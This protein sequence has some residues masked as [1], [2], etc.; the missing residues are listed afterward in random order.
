MEMKHVPG[1][2]YSCLDDSQIT[3][4]RVPTALEYTAT[5]SESRHQGPDHTPAFF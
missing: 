4:I 2:K 5:L 3:N 1:E